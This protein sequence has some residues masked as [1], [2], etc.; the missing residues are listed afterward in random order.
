MVGFWGTF[1]HPLFKLGFQETGNWLIPPPNPTPTPNP[2][3]STSYFS[4]RSIMRLHLVFALSGIMHAAG[5]WVTPG[6]TPWHSFLAFFFQANAI[7]L[8]ELVRA[9]LKKL[10]AR[11]VVQKLGV[12]VFVL[13]WS[14]LTMPLLVGDMAVAKYWHAKALPFCIIGCGSDGHPGLDFLGVSS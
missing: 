11:K 6:T 12:L 2:K 8:Q 9:G 1:W 14:L 4:L 3:S 5:S 7:V 10:G 13:G